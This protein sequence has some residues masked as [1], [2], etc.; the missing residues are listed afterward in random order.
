M[1]YELEEHVPENQHLRDFELRML[2]R[3]SGDNAGQVGFQNPRSRT[4]EET[5]AGK[6]EERAGSRSPS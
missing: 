3:T 5:S 2:V 4:V 1:L 6:M